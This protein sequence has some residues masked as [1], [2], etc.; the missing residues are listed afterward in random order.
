MDILALIQGMG[1]L[2]FFSSRAFL[3]AFLTACL[4]RFGNHLPW[5]RNTDFIKAMATEPTWFTSNWCI[6]ILGILAILEI[7]GDKVPEIRQ[8]MNKT[9]DYIKPVA[10]LL[11]Y[12]GVVSGAD[13]RL[14]ET[15]IHA[16]YLD[17][18]PAVLV[19]FGVAL[20]TSFRNTLLNLIV[21]TDEDDEL[22]LRTL[23]SWF[24]DIGISAG[25]LLLVFYPLV[26]LVLC[27]LISG[28]ISGAAMLMRRREEKSKIS[29]QSCH[30][31][32]SPVALKCPKCL[33]ANVLVRKL[34]FF[35][36]PLDVLVDNP[37]EHELDLVEK[38]RCPCCATRFT[39][40]QVRQSCQECGYELMSDP[41]FVRSYA[42]RIRNRLPST[43]LVTW[44]LSLIPAVGLIPGIM[45]YRYRLA[46]PF[47]RYIP[48]HKNLFINLVI[49]LIFILLIVLQLIPL[50]GSISVPV[51]ALITYLV[52]R[53][54]Y[55]REALS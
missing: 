26:M 17:Y 52:Y 22:G 30:A 7:A 23:L 35:A 49:Q 16:G 21:E 5:I 19:A 18:I 41:E 24:E 42:R 29:C 43:L 9:I 27:G 10:A 55:T 8:T 39:Q 44:L 13:A 31:S 50:V 46:G 36:Q 54:S 3:P 38:K 1:T 47:R 4:I 53:N 48:M 33:N 15:I 12:L 11:T 40:K 14:L 25:I 2:A 32:F 20:L 28:L 37:H 34:G 51:M 6:V 45:Y